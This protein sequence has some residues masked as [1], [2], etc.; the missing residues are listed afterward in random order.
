L[1]LIKALEAARGNGTSMISLI[2]PP[3]D[4]VGLQ[5][6]LLV[7]AASRNC[8]HI[9][10]RYIS[11]HVFKSCSIPCASLLHPEQL[12]LGRL[13]VASSWPGYLIVSC[14]HAAQPNTHLQHFT[15][16]E[17]TCGASPA[18][19]ASFLLLLL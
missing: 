11:A 5:L 16:A 14:L 9:Q 8:I 10:F 7:V 1:Q 19:C 6:L 18:F 15:H 3:K 4:Q 17:T 2:L 13:L 12:L